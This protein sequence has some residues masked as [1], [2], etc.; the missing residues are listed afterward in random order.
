M[1]SKISNGL[2][3]TLPLRNRESKASASVAACANTLC[4]LQVLRVLVLLDE[5]EV[6]ARQE[7]RPR[8]TPG[9][10]VAEILVRKYNNVT[11]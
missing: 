2:R 8:P 4:C 7:G 6:A 11:P 3:G 10:V 1:P 9:H 5:S